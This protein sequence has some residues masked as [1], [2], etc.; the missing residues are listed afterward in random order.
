MKKSRLLL[1][2]VSLFIA[3]GNARA[4]QLIEKM[5]ARPDGMVIP[6]E[7]YKLPNG[8]TVIVH[9]DH[10]DPIVNIQVTYKVGSD[11]ESIGKSGFAHFFE[12]MMF[13]GS[14]HVKDEEHFHIVS[15]AGGTMNGYTQKDK[16]VYFET[17]PSNQLEVA[18]WLESDRMGFLI[19]SLTTKKFENQ[20]DAVKNEKGQNVENQPYAMAFSEILNQTLYP[21]KHPY[22]WPVIGYTDDL[23]RATLEDVKNFFL[24]WYG[25]NNAILNVSGDVD[26]KQVLQLA[27]KY[28][29]PIN[30][31]PEVKK[32]KVAPFTLPNDKYA[33]YK[34]NI[35]LPLNLRVYPTV[36]QYHRDEPALE[37]MAYMMGSGNN[38]IFYKNFVKSKEA[39]QASV[40]HSPGELGG[41]FQM[42]VLAY[43]PEDFN[44]QKMFNELD[45]K[46]KATIEEFEK[47]GITDESLQRAKASKESELING[48]SSVFGKSALLSEWDR[49]VGKPYN[50]SDELDR[51]NKVTKEDISKVLN[52]YIKGAGAAVVD[53][54]PKGMSKDSVKSFNPYAGLQLGPDPEYANVKYNRPVDTFDR[55]RK[56][57]GA[58]PK[59]TKVPEF[60]TQDM[61]NGLRVYGTRET[62][63]PEI[64]IYM[65]MEGGDLL[66]KPE[67]AKK[68]GIASLTADVMNEGTKNYTTEQI[69]AE[70]EKLGSSISFSGTKENTTVTINCLKKN[71]DATLKLFE[72]KL[73]NPKFDPED[74]KRVKKQYKEALRDEKTSPE[75]LANKAYLNVLYGNTPFGLA[76]TVKNVDKLELEDV[77]DYYNKYYSPSV[78]TLSIVGDITDKEILPK[79]AF[80]EKW[81][82]KEV[83][84][85]PVIP[86]QTAVE[87]Q[88]FIVDRPASPQS[89]IMMGYPSMP[90]D[91]TGEYFKNSVVNYPFGGAFNSRLNLNLREDKGYTYGIRSGFAGGPYNGNFTVST[92]VKRIATANSLAEIVKETQNY[93][94]N[95]VKDEELS[96]T[97]NSLLNSEALKYESS[98]QKA[99]FLTKIAR[100][101]L[102]KDFTAQQAQILKGMTKEEFNMQVKKSIKPE[103]M[104][105]VIVGD[106]EI[107]KKQLDKMAEAN[108]Q[109]KLGKV[110]DLNFD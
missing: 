105:I 81:A 65:Q 97:K 45:G 69:S 71:L 85:K 104:S 86:A 44:F 66:L 94:Q 30:A 36:P 19:D 7:K 61:K 29:G 28:F 21:F 56:P 83:T 98:F 2:M 110:K 33:S 5:D 15:E 1:L 22:S 87:P 39:I 53:V 93:V 3:L 68:M 58:A 102:S 48:E 34:D 62:E 26:T 37:L 11:R 27:M 43:P 70:L 73:Y 78:A 6:Y 10:S 42:Y 46:V 96:F 95:G 84:I 82:P 20:R 13:Q 75:A 35:Y 31:S 55:S 79:L 99:L 106:K 100:Y 47:T 101:R 12:H 72:E 107:I 91:A 25:P 16:T 89:V 77:K 32:M 67:D 17:V 9:E 59:T 50:L 18:F 63:T 8:L 80:L 24:R 23:N 52:K 41:E 51:F 109:L 38:S 40:S 76:P 64:V 57:E 88:I 90:Y 108:K 4:Q 49:L 60:Y 92:S 54:Y 14:N 74:F 103:N